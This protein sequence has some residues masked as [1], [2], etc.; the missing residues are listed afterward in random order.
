MKASND[1]TAPPGGG[2]SKALLVLVLGLAALLRLMNLPGRY[3]IRDWD[4]IAYES[5]GLVAWEGISPGLRSVP[6]GP[7]TWVGWLYAAGCSGWE[8]LHPSREAA[9]PKVLKPYLA[10][11]QALF[12][13][14][15]DLSGL[16][17]VMLAVSFAVG[18]AG[19]WGGYRLGAKY[20]GS[21][22][23][24]L[25]GGLVAAL[26]IYVELCAQTRSTSDAWMLAILAISCAATLR[27]AKQKW[28]PGVLLGLA[29]AS[30]I[31]MVIAGPLVLWALWDNSEPGAAW[32][33]IFATVG[34]TLVG[35]VLAAPWAVG[36]FLTMLRSIAMV[37]VLAM[38]FT[39]HSP[40]VATLCSLAWEEGL[41]P[42]LV[43]TFVGVWLLPAGTRLR[44]GVLVAFAA[45]MA[46]TMFTGPYEPMRYHGGPLIALLT[47]AA[48]AVGALLLRWPKAALALGGVLVALPLVQSVRTVLQ[49]RAAYVPEAAAQWIDEHVPPGTVVYLHPGF[50]VRAVLPT[51]AA[52]DAIWRMSASDE[53]WRIKLQ[54]GLQRYS[55]KGTRLPRALSEDNL[56]ADRSYCR[57]WFILG[58]GRS[59]R[60]RY[61]VRLVAASATFG[62]QRTTLVKAYQE[63]GGVVLWP[64][65]AGG[66][67][68][69]LGEPRM[70]WVN[71]S[72]QGTLVFISPDVGEKLK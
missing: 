22:G 12:K 27:G 38:V 4:E 8:I 35:A 21:A 18:L 48:V 45:L 62:L 19:V 2:S 17:R 57:R 44:R 3:E 6:S 10:I 50:I 52:A 46:A 29:I 9:A 7:E 47:C 13:T 65:A 31:D 61:D 67:P 54:D 15:E 11:D 32:K 5:C 70:K 66:M 60:P 58:G 26:P 39:T 51:E 30:R 37:R 69:G 16:R 41:G 42:V 43:A 34:W 36:G 40:R 28:L 23:G 64:V 55:L 14:Y 59:E 71:S 1:Q 63:T 49:L 72:G 33:W 56:C 53:A 25:I 68:D 24:L 20:G